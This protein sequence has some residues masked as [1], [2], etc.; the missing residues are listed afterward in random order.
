[1]LI[2]VLWNVKGILF[3]VLEP[4]FFQREELSSYHSRLT[5]YYNLSSLWDASQTSVAFTQHG[6]TIW[7]DSLD[8]CLSCN[9][10]KIQ[11]SAYSPVWKCEKICIYPVFSLDRNSS[12]WSAVFVNTVEAVCIK[13]FL[14]IDIGK[15]VHFA[16]SQ[17]VFGHRS[18]KM[19]I[20]SD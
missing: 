20:F 1:M 7:P 14:L 8:G 15:T 5:I 4:H 11:F 3:W 12:F 2:H 9:F 19:F 17:Y 13:T 10:P 16:Y 18:Y 6:G